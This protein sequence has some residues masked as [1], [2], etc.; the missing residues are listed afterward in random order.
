[1]RRGNQAGWTII[2]LAIVLTVSSIVTT[3]VVPAF[4]ETIDRNRLAVSANALLTDLAMARQ[5]AV[6]RGRPVT[7]CAGNAVSGC[8]GDWSGREWIVFVDAD[9][10][11]RFDVGESLQSTGDL[12]GMPGL[13]V[14]G[15][16]PFVSA[17]VFDP[18]G[19][20]HLASGAF[21]AGTL[22]MC[23][24]AGVTDLVLSAGGRVRAETRDFSG[25]CPNP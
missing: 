4:T 7:L 23:L 12:R 15:N 16:G 18:I 14:K 10:D 19:T 24:K 22:R 6:M 9:H 1:M 2:E 3:L 21:A 5:R 8:T 13:V 25:S 11:G 17:I 20:S